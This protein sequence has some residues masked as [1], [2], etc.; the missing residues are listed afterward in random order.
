MENVETKPYCGEEV[1]GNTPTT[2]QNKKY[3]C[4]NH[5]E[6]AYQLHGGSFG[7]YDEL[8]LVFTADNLDTAR[9]FAW[10]FLA[11]HEIDAD[12]IGHRLLSHNYRN[13]FKAGY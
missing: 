13:K 1:A 5:Y 8:R 7:Y 12:Y 3:S 9:S 4:L 2:Q 6:L 10:H 11:Y